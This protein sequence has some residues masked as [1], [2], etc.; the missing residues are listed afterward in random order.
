MHQESTLQ[1]LVTYLVGL[2]RLI[3]HQ[4]NVLST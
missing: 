1:T 2:V 3:N 4:V